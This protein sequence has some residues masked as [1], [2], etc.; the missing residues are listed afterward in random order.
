MWK[1]HLESR[2]Q[3]NSI[4]SHVTFGRT[5]SQTLANRCH[6]RSS[7]QLLLLF[8]GE[9][10]RPASLRR[11]RRAQKLCIRSR[12]S[13]LAQ[14]RHDMIAADAAFWS[15]KKCGHG[16]RAKLAQC[17]VQ[18]FDVMGRPKDILYTSHN[19][20]DRTGGN[21]HGWRNDTTF[22]NRHQRCIFMYFVSSLE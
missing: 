3:N 19:L 7:E 17:A 14:K 6:G 10:Q 11:H 1:N 8:R 12:L 18:L 13:T 5:T 15:R 21:H 16:A 9:P 22:Y 4:G 2:W 20:H